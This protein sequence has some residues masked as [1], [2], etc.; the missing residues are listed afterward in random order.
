[1]CLILFL[2]AA[3]ASGSPSGGTLF[4]TDKSPSGT[5]LAEQF[6][7]EASNPRFDVPRRE[8]WLR[9][10][11]GKSAPSLLFE[12]F[13][14]AEVLFSPNDRWIAI[15]DYWGSGSAEVRLFQKTS[16]LKYPENKK[17]EPTK[18]CWALLDRTVGRPV[19]KQLDH[20]YMRAIQWAGDSRAVLLAA[21]GHLSGEPLEV[22]DWLCVFDV[23]RLEA[24]TDMRL[25]NRGA[26][27]DRRDP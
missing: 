10:T 16:G 25:M 9:D 13:R 21:W 8:I 17:A 7:F 27:Q 23:E 2:F 6:I 12:H 3:L 5:L 1:M 26:V 19:S 15:S 24:S 18:K 4:Q 11:Q 14:Q 22:R 20:S